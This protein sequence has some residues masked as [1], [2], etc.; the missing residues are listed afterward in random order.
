MKDL[1]LAQVKEQL[2]QSGFAGS[3]PFNDYT[4]MQYTTAEGIKFHICLDVKKPNRVDCL[5]ACKPGKIMADGLVGNFVS[6][7]G[8][9][10][11]FSFDSA[12]QLI[13]KIEA[14]KDFLFW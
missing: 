11:R 9:M 12:E 14:I 8:R 6:G 10:K 13:K 5:R 4:M 2:L 1:T 7:P 3:Y